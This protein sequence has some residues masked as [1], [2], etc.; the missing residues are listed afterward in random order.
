MTEGT[1]HAHMRELWSGNFNLLIVNRNLWKCFG[2]G[3]EMTW[4]MWLNCY[5]PCFY[6]A[7]FIF[8]NKTGNTETTQEAT[9]EE[10]RALVVQTA[11]FLIQKKL[12]VKFRIYFED[13]PGRACW[14][15]ECWLTARD[16]CLWVFWGLR[17]QMNSIN[18]IFVDRTKTAEHEELGI[19]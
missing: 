2:K 15:A 12:Q 16:K 10:S 17:S 1:E 3:S 7:S 6:T 19:F 18:N 9:S 11:V 4:F 8:R 5:H 14:Y 13:R